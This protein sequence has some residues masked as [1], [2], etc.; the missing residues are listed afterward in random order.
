MRRACFQ[1]VATLGLLLWLTTTGCRLR[2]S[3]PCANQDQGYLQS[4]TRTIE[5]PDVESEPTV[6]IRGSLRPIVLSEKS[7]PPIHDLTLQEAIELALEN[8]P[9]LRDMGGLVL[10]APQALP[11]ALSPSLAEMD[12]RF[13]VEAALS[14][15]DAMF[16][17]NAYFEKN[18]RA[19]NNQVT[20]LGTQLFQQ[21]LNTYNFELRKRTAAG[22]TLAVREKLDY[23]F[24]N[25]PFNN[26]PN[27]PW[28]SRFE[29]EF[30]QPLFQGAGTEFNR[31]AGPNSTPGFYN[32]V[33]I[34]R[35]NTDIALAD[36]EAGVTQLLSNVENAYWEL[37][38]AFRDL[39]AKIAARDLAYQTW[40]QI[41]VL[42]KRG[43]GGAVEAV[44]EALAREQL[45]RLEAE[46]QNAL[47]GRLIEK[48]NANVFRGPTGVYAAERRLR[49]AIGLP[50]AD[51]TLLRPSD[52]PPAAPV[53][54]EWAGLLDEALTRRVE[55]RRQKWVV[56]RREM[57]LLASRNFL[58]PRLDAIGLYR[59]RGLGHDML[60]NS[61][62]YFGSAFDNM[63]TGDFQEWMVGME[64]LAPIG[65]R[66][67]HAA[68]RHAELNLAR[69]RAIL[70]EQEKEVVSDLA[71][72]VAE[73]DRA[74]ELAKTNYNRRMA[75]IHQL[76][77][78]EPLL[79]EPDAA[80]KP[81]LLDLQLDAQR[82]LADAETQYYAS[83]CEH[84]VAIKNLHLQKG[85][86]LEFNRIYLAEGDWPAQ[87]FHD[88]ARRDRLRRNA[89]HLDNY[90]RHGPIVSRGPYAQEQGFSSE[91]HIDTRAPAPEDLPPP[92]P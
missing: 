38:L 73:I 36:F 57:E 61:N 81:R 39:D 25:S 2:D 47:A 41:D 33:L 88:A 11:T 7:P 18:D 54:F 27:L 23:D 76:E 6:G 45:L 43:A 75:A 50:A 71:G 77:T 64:F 90:V 65:Y 69:E 56:K 24:N 68:V 46:V 78:L 10:Q 40:H 12:P 53:A 13:G 31:I 89:L 80:E 70:T 67:G 83:L 62:Q 66:Q 74:F 60:S 37:Y 59:F 49:R 42:S 48:S 34:A 82:R 32:G 84:A 14:A 22:T 4:R 51:G 28:T 55:L 1:R 19:F 79:K 72:A 58:L 26:N 92:A 8:S 16:G 91:T 52:E 44:S 20:G 9:V 21:D 3:L 87:A 17:A 86:L 85:G 30:R 5:Y 29:G 63:A 15:F 35:V